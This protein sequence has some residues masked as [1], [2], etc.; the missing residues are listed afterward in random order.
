MKLL[1]RSEEVILLAV[2][3][4]RDN[5]YGVT[6]RDLA[7]KSTGYE[8]DFAAVYIALDK[9]TRKGYVNKTLSKP[10]AERGGR[11]KCMYTL[12]LDGKNALKSIQKV[13]KTLWQGISDAAFDSEG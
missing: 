6:I 2:W 13:H 11:S 12:T 10:I 7:S 3:R 1:S 5:A 8:W 9:L 4:L